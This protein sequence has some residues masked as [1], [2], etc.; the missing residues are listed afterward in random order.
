MSL[1]RALRRMQLLDLGYWVTTVAVPEFVGRVEKGVMDF[2]DWE[3]YWNG[4]EL[5]KNIF[6]ARI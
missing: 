4:K 3:I 5:F 2:D 1:F 6:K